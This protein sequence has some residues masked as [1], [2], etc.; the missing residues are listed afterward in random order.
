MTE[1]LPSVIHCSMICSHKDPLRVV[2]LVMATILR[3][4]QVEAKNNHLVE[5]IYFYTM[6]N[7]SYDHAW[8]YIASS[9]TRRRES[10]G[11]VDLRRLKDR[12]AAHP[13]LS[14]SR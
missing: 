11:E 8:Y 14:K 2:P 5:G 9:I 7:F 10:L 3:L 6:Y 4:T 13:L 12:L 1:F